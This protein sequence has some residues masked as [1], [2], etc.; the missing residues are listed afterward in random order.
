MHQ[1]ATAADRID[2]WI[3]RR[4]VACALPG[5]ANPAS[6]RYVGLTAAIGQSLRDQYDALAA[7]AASRLTGQATSGPRRDAKQLTPLSLK[8]HFGGAFLPGAVHL[9]NRR[10]RESKKSP[11]AAPRGFSDQMK[12]RLVA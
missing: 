9:R 2:Y 1:V 6:D 12:E 5:N 7:P 4:I 11:G 8:P 3:R 10:D